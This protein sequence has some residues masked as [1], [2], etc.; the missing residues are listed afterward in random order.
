MNMFEEW[1]KRGTII[2]NKISGNKKLRVLFNEV[3]KYISIP[4]PMS[5]IF[6]IKQSAKIWK[7]IST[8][9]VVDIKL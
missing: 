3:I 9:I 6:D 5:P 7:I 8:S 1:I 4:S 2:G